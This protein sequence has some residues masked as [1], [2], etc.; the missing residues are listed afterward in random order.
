MK[1]YLLVL[2]LNC[3]SIQAQKLKIDSLLH[4]SNNFKTNKEFQKA[5]DLDSSIIRS[6]NFSK[7][8]FPLSIYDIG[9]IYLIQNDTI[10]AI[11]IFKSLINQSIHSEILNDWLFYKNLAATKLFEIYL[12]K[13]EIKK[14]IYYHY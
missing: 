1:S 9:D 14:A 8:E 12:N 7:F 5:I 2:L 11:R 4:L 6:S 3:L 10:N 13:N